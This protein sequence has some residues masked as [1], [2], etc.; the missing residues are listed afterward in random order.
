MPPPPYLAARGQESA[1]VHHEVFD[2]E[3]HL[4]LRVHRTIRAI[5]ADLHLEALPR[6]LKGLNELDRAIGLGGGT[7]HSKDEA[8]HALEYSQAHNRPPGHLR[9]LQGGGDQT[10]RISFIRCSYATR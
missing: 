6:T 8:W 5:G 1:R 4:T 9:L 10:R 7:R 3:L 2:E